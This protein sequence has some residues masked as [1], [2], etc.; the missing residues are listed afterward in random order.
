MDIFGF[1]KKNHSLFSD[2]KWSHKEA[3]WALGDFFK[4]KF[5]LGRRGI[6]KKASFPSPP[7]VEWVVGGGGGGAGGVRGGGGAGGVRVRG[8]GG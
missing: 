4:R 6:L 5:G 3:I 8:G 1:K 2:S 7:H